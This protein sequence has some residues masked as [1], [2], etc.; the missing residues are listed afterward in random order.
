M[1]TVLFTVFGALF[2]MIELA[3]KYNEGGLATVLFI[4]IYRTV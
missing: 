1:R 4:D 3:R 2:D